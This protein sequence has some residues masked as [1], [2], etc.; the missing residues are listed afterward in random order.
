MFDEWKA[1]IEAAHGEGHTV[2]FATLIVTK[3]ELA[4][5]ATSEQRKALIKAKAENVADSLTAGVLDRIE[6]E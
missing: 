3:Q 2:A 4:I 5:A 6:I 1:E